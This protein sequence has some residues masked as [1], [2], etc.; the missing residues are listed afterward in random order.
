MDSK[1]IIKQESEIEFIIGFPLD[2]V[3]SKVLNKLDEIMKEFIGSSPLVFMSTIDEK[4][5]VDVSP[6]GDPCGF[7]KVDASGNLLIPDRPGNKLTFGHRNIIR[8]GEIGLIFLV[9]NQRETLRVKG[10]ATL[11]NDPNI[12]A[13]LQVNNKPAL[14]CTS[15]EV[16]ECFMH[17]GKALIRSKLWQPEAWDT[18]ETSL[19]TKQFAPIFGGGTDENAVQKTQDLLDKAYKDELY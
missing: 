10:I 9:P 6:K 5:H 14:L 18:S 13:E 1:Y 19:G 16:K 8:N 11:H 3:K 15:I 2:I 7:V 12:L 4:G 17:C